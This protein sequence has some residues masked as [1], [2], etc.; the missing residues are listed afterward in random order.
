M[1]LK[2]RFHKKK[3][4]TLTLCDPVSALERIN[5]NLIY[6]I[7]TEIKEMGQ[8][9]PL[10]FLSDW[11]SFIFNHYFEFIMKL[12][13]DS[14]FTYIPVSWDDCVSFNRNT[15]YQEI[16]KIIAEKKILIALFKAP[17]WFV[18]L[19]HFINEDKAKATNL[20]DYL[21]LMYN[22]HEEDG[23]KVTVSYHILKTP[24][25]I[26]DA[27]LDYK[28]PITKNTYIGI[29]M[30]FISIVFGTIDILP[31]V[32]LLTSFSQIFIFFGILFILAD[33]KQLI[34][35]I[36]QRSSLNKLV[37]KQKK[38]LKRRLDS[39][40]SLVYL[41][42]FSRRISSTLAV[43][44]LHIVHK[45]KIYFNDTKLL[46][47][48]QSNINMQITNFE[49]SKI[50]EILQSKGYIE[51]DN[52]LLIKTTISDSLFK[53][54]KLLDQRLYEDFDLSEQL[55]EKLYLMYAKFRELTLNICI[56]ADVKPP[57]LPDCR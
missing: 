8:D 12:A 42:T 47:L 20:S 32:E 52:D 31:G 46:S 23:K 17:K 48:I 43:T 2:K 13:E 49:V 44:I 39:T 15:S 22:P 16:N 55:E 56:L 18:Y 37:T 34:E 50:L 6:E 9:L 14:F 19:S 30:T 11:R 38:K 10:S 54:K 45:N 7:M 21:F 4:I 41:E 5:K 35:N 57:N 25:E 24:E 3:M 28:Q 33:A 51:I 27:E 40:Q 1:P 26:L 53:N 29:A 36:F